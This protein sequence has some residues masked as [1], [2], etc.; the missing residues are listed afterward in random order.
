MVYAVLL[1]EPVTVT[2]ILPDVLAAPNE[3]VLEAALTAPVVAKFVALTMFDSV[4]AL[5]AYGNVVFY[6]LFD[7][8]F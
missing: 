2:L 7:H 8:P 6:T 1:P 4:P 5:Y 3:L